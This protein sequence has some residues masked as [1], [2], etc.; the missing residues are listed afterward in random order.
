MI[1]TADLSNMAFPFFQARQIELGSAPVRALRLSYVG[2]LGWE[3]HHPI[4][5]QRY[6]YDLLMD[7]GDGMGL[8]DFGYRALEAMRLEKGYR[9][10]GAD[11]ST[12]YTPFEAGLGRFVDLEKGEFIGRSRLLEDAGKPLKVTLA[13]LRLD[14]GELPYGNEPILAHDRIVGYVAS[15]GYGPSVESDIAYG[16]LPPSDA[17]D[18]NRLTLAI[19]GER[20]PA[21]VCRV[22]IFDPDNS[23]MKG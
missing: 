22:P 19:R 17:A 4:E 2:E 5:Y 9:L 14:P 18:G 7:A 8:V 21:T 12:D 15:A 1:T 23:R 11:I 16:Y 10:W 20:R 3:L 13:C 6:L